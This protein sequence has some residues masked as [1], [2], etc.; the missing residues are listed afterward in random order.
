TEPHVKNISGKLW[1]LRI[2]STSDISRIFY[3]IPVGKNIVLLHGFVKK[4][5]KTPNREIQTANN[6]LEDYQRRN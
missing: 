1:E 3:F 4:T 6:Y 5:Q 2:K